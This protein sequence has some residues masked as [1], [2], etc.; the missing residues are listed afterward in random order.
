VDV[1]SACHLMVVLISLER[2][3]ESIVSHT[4]HSQLHLHLIHRET[5]KHRELGNERH[6][7]QAS[8]ELISKRRQHWHSVRTVDQP[9]PTVHSTSL[10]S[11]QW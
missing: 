5:C 4:E 10:Y 2:F 6:M 1:L 9:V 8:E 7:K 3:V 11:S